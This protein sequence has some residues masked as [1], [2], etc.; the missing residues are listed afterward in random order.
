[1]QTLVVFIVA[2]IVIGIVVFVDGYVNGQEYMK[3]AFMNN[4]LYVT[5][6]DLE[7]YVKDMR[8]NGAKEDEII[9]MVKPEWWEDETE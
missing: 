6:K 7:D 3:N 8:D 5:I 4:T 9:V 1:M 2:F